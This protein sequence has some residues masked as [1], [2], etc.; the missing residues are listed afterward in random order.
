MMGTSRVFYAPGETRRFIAVDA[1]QLNVQQHHAVILIQEMLERLFAGLR[2]H[3]DP[4]VGGQERFQRQEALR[5]IV[6][7]Q[8][9]RLDVI[10]LGQVQGFLP[11]RYP[12]TPSVRSQAC[13]YSTLPTIDVGAGWRYPSCAEEAFD[14][15][16]F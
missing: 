9:T 12:H 13:S 14:T 1:G 8:Q 15:T 16:R 11:V 5:I 3:D 10:R 6:D 4:I 7:E 2:F